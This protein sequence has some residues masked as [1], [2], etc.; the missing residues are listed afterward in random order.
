MRRESESDCDLYGCI[1]DVQA[2]HPPSPHGTVHTRAFSSFHSGGGRPRVRGGGPPQGLLPPCAPAQEPAGTC[3]KERINTAGIRLHICTCLPLS[4]CISIHP[5][6]SPPSPW[7]EG[8]ADVS[9]IAPPHTHPAFRARVEEVCNVAGVHVSL[10]P[11]CY[12][13]MDGWMDGR[14]FHPP[15][16][17]SLP[18]PQ[19]TPHQSA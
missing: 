9:R 6:N 16:T 17:Q 10:P 19:T 8:M 7:Q 5:N 13:W 2:T 1:C 4:A 14:H 12:A 11:A 3:Y 15:N 18:L